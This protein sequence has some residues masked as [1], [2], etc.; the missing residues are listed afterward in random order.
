MRNWFKDQQI[1][2][3]TVSLWVKRDTDNDGRVGLVNNG[4]CVNDTTFGIYGNENPSEQ[5]VIGVLDTVNN[6]LAQTGPLHVSIWI[7]MSSIQNIAIC[8][9][10]GCHDNDFTT[11]SCCSPSATV[12][13]SVS[14]P[15]YRTLT[16]DFDTCVAISEKH[17][18]VDMKYMH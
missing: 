15:H 14:L 11:Y 17:F 18:I 4:D 9:P 12:Q 6:P 5:I 1:M 16:C 8:I 10:G 2:G 7:S 3:F 13:G